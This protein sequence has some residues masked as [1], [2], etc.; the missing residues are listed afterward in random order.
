MRPGRHVLTPGE[1]AD[2]VTVKD[3]LD[4]RA[5]LED[6]GGPAYVASLID[7]VPRSTNVG[8][9]A[10]IVKEDGGSAGP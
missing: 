1:A 5:S 3:E 7:G 2:L 6:V 8:H 9:Y 4:R 10:R